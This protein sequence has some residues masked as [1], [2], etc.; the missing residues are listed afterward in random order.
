MAI[1][2][3]KI[4]LLVVF[5]LAVIFLVPFF[6]AQNFSPAADEIT[7]LPSGYS[8]WKT[9]KIE[10]NPQHPPLVKLLASFPL[11]FLDLNFD[12]N[13][14]YLVGEWK[15]EWE[16]GRKF[17][18]SNNADKLL[19]L[20]RLTPVLLSVLLGFYVFKWA[21][22][23]F[24]YRAGI[25]SLFLYTFMPSI[26]AHAQFVATDLAVSVFSFITLYYLWR[27]FKS[28]DAKFIKYVGIGLGLTLASKF[29]GLTMV[30]IVIFLIFVY[31][32]QKG[33]IAKNDDFIKWNALILG[34]GFLVAYVFYLFPLN[35]TFYIDGLNS[36]YRDATTGYHFYLN[37]NFSENGW[38]YYFIWAFIIKTPI[39]ALAVFLLSFLAYKKYN[40]TG[41]EKMTILVPVV[42]YFVLIS[43][44]AGNIGVRYILP[45][46]PF[47]ILY[48]GGLMSFKLNLNKKLLFAC[49]AGLGIW[50]VFSAVKIY[51]DYL[52]YFNELVGGPAN[53]HKY[54]DDSNIDWYQDLKRLKAYQVEHPE[55]KVMYSWRRSS[56][57]YYGIK[58]DLLSSAINL[59]SLASPSGRFAISTNLLIRMKFGHTMQDEVPDW[60]ALYEPVDRIGYSFFVYEF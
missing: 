38:W 1:V 25:L 22:E 20:G 54:L 26:I 8:Y 14:P 24:N 6:S 48:A 19:L 51:P 5:F 43:M 32:L 46:Y 52:A 41:L 12:K 29:S 16:F 58:N 50:Y 53:G 57:Q 18:F 55:T 47:L 11:L 34:L 33:D 36:V 28:G 3:Y 60:L 17:L 39:P 2:N 44:K 40:L 37:G 35:A 27:F 49:I 10:L 23:M 30:P 4:K 59:S 42:A 13:D 45:V 15:N 31:S 56:P 7:H 9:G 21:S